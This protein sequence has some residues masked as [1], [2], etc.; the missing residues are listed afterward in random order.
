MMQLKEEN[1]LTNRGHVANISTPLSFVFLS[2]K[3]VTSLPSHRD[4]VVKIS[5]QMCGCVLAAVF[6]NWELSR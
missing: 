1:L 6:K 4:V 5:L 2:C 3:L